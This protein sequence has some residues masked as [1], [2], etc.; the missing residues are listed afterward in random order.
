MNKYRYKPFYSRNHENE[1]VIVCGLGDESEK[2]VRQLVAYNI[3]F[4]YF[5]H[6][7]ND[8]IGNEKLGKKVLSIAQVGALKQDY[9]IQILVPE[10]CADFYNDLLKKNNLEQ[11]ITCIDNL[12]EISDEVME[13]DKLVI[14]GPLEKANNIKDKLINKDDILIVNQ[15][16]S[17]DE[18]RKNSEDIDIICLNDSEKELLFLNIINFRSVFFEGYYCPEKV[19]VH[20][21]KWYDRRIALFGNDLNVFYVKNGL[22]IFDIEIENI[23]T[24]SDGIIAYG[25]DS[26]FEAVYTD[27]RGYVIVD[28]NRS[29]EYDNDVKNLQSIIPDIKVYHFKNPYSLMKKDNLQNK[30]VL[31]PL[32]ARSINEGRWH[33]IQ[34][35]GEKNDTAPIIFITGG[36]TSSS[37]LFVEKSWPEFFSDILKEN[38][39]QY[40]IFNSASEGDRAYQEFIKLFRDGICLNPHLVITYDGANEMLRNAQHDDF[41]YQTFHKKLFERMA[42]K[43]SGAVLEL[44]NIQTFKDDFFRWFYY[45]RC[46]N[47]ICKEFDVEYKCFCQPILFSKPKPDDVE[48]N[49]ILSLN[50]GDVHDEFLEPYKIFR[51]KAMELEKRDLS[52]FKDLSNV[53]DDI[54]DVYIDHTHLLEKGNRI[55]AE[56]IFEEVKDYL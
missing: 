55:I 14:W 33:G 24:E 51:N 11:Y 36:S 52:W 17:I 34:I 37:D 10:E 41:Y 28:C 43:S 8:I 18:L 50:Y 29:D 20:L 7:S 21:C 25:A 47:A 16:I 3:Y 1:I 5:L 13:S 44:G 38:R 39:L 40:R 19:Y 2:V 26:I 12:I 31:D 6:T 35:I 56:K 22:K 53:F 27:D 46:M 54:S 42:V 15:D 45:M 4:N 48:K 9:K 30:K 32:V 49:I 23:F